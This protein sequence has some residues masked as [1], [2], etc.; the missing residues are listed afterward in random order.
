M[1]YSESVEVPARLE[2]SGNGLG[3]LEPFDVQLVG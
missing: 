3:E 1:Y 2:H